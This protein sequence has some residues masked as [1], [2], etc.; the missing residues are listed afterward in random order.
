MNLRALDKAHIAAHDIGG[1]IGMRFALFHPQK[2]KYL[3]LLDTV[4]YNSWP[5]TT[6]Q[7]IIA[8]GLE[9]LIHSS[10]YD[11]RNRMKKQPSILLR[12][13]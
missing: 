4:S 3:P 6:W 7:Q 1:A 10:G 12:R 8:N 5:S 9:S 13:I 11:H 2:T